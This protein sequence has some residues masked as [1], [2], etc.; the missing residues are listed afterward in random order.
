VVYRSTTSASIKLCPGAAEVRVL[1]HVA[2]EARVH[3][4]IRFC[5]G[6]AKPRPA[7]SPAISAL[8]LA[9]ARL[10]EEE[11]DGASQEVL[12]GPSR[13]L[14]VGHHGEQA[15]RETPVVFIVVLAARL[16]P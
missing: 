3:G 14:G 6:P 10:L 4:C 5:P 1:G 9:D 16:L 12:A 8:D 2:P 7:R 11:T 15:L 13:C